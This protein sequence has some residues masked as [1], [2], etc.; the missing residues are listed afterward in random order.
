[1]ID[2]DH[3]VRTIPILIFLTSILEIIVIIIRVRYR[4]NFTVVRK[5]KKGGRKRVRKKIEN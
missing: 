1:M 4:L 5:K 2:I 3:A